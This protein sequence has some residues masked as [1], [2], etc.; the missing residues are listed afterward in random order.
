MCTVD[1]DLGKCAD[2]LRKVLHVQRNRAEHF[3]LFTGSRRID[4]D[5]HIII[6][7]IIKGTDIIVIIIIMIIIRCLC[8]HKLLSI[9]TVSWGHIND[10][11]TLYVHT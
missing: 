5:D 2:D 7:M 10:E 11:C 1:D 6:M 9:K 3:L 8:L 4:I